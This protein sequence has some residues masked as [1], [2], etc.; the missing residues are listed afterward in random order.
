MVPGIPRRPG[1]AVPAGAPDGPTLRLPS[2]ASVPSA[3]QISRARAT[4]WS[5]TASAICSARAGV[6]RSGRPYQPVAAIWRKSRST[7]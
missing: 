5:A 3:S 2:P 4:T 6:A 1:D 7:G